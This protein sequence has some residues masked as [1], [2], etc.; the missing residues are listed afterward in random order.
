M[1]RLL[2]FFVVTTSLLMHRWSVE[3]LFIWDGHLSDW[4][5][6]AAVYALQAIGL[7]IGLLM[8]RRPLQRRP[9]VSLGLLVTVP[10]TFHQRS[11]WV[12]HR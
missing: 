8:L 11:C 10:L 5:K 1:G 12:R 2:G 6:I 4:R 3:K 9:L 7:T